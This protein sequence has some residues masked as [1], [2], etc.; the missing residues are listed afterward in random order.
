MPSVEEFIYVEAPLEAVYRL[1]ADLAQHARFLPSN[2]RYV[3][4]LTP[5][6]DRPGARI[7]VKIKLV[8]PFWQEGVVQLHALEP[9]RCVVE[10]PPD[11]ANFMTRWTLVPEPPGTMVVVH[12]DFV[13][14]SGGG[15]GGLVG[16]R[17]ETTMSRAYR[18]SLT[19]L[20]AIVEAEAPPRR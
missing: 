20:K 16:G 8:G 10:G 7:A 3:R 14:P 17:L 1:V 4:A 5:V 19:R 12:T 11:A 2:A 15:L 18:E 13:P 6:T 9:P